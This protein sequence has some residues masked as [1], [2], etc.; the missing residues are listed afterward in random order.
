MKECY[1]TDCNRHLNCYTTNI[2]SAKEMLLSN[3][4][5]DVL[6]SKQNNAKKH[7]LIIHFLRDMPQK[8]NFID[9]EKNSYKGIIYKQK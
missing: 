3:F 2:D 5:D 6:D 9:D 7:I 1:K 8:Y 4:I